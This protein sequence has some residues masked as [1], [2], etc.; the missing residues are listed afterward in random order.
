MAGMISQHI[1]RK[2][3]HIKRVQSN[4]SAFSVTPADLK[5]SLEWARSIA[6][7][8]RDLVDQPDPGY[9]LDPFWAHFYPYRVEAGDQKER[10]TASLRVRNYLDRPVPLSATLVLPPGVQAKPQR[11]KAVILPKTESAVEFELDIQP[12]GGG[13]KRVLLADITMDGRYFGQVAEMLIDAPV[14][15]PSKSLR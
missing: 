14:H 8:L 4:A 12:Q 1:Y 11:A 9:G 15:L 10:S 6:P 2:S 13:R 5:R 3:Q 7:A